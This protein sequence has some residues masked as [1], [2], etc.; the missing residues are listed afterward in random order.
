MSERERLILQ[1]NDI[2]VAAAALELVSASESSL[3]GP[4]KP[5][6]WDALTSHQDAHALRV[7]GGLVK[8]GQLTLRARTGIKPNGA[9]GPI[10]KLSSAFYSDGLL[11]STD[12][13]IREYGGLARAIARQPGQT[14]VRVE[15]QD[16]GDLGE[17]VGFGYVRIASTG[18]KTANEVGM[19]PLQRI[20]N[21]RS[22]QG[23]Y[24]LDTVTGVWQTI[25]IYPAPH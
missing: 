16:V 5:A 8:D 3:F 15:V 23:I 10:P 22:A 24:E 21:L 25:T 18:N 19:G 7:H 13:A 11:I 17:S 12:Q 14:V 2:C 9:H 1:V 6:N 4:V 20:D